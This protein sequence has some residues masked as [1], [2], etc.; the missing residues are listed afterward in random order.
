MVVKYG[1]LYIIEKFL[2]RD[3]QN[4]QLQ[5]FTDNLEYTV[6]TRPMYTRNIYERQT[7]T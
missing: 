1:M 5:K 3:L 7:T 2:P 6:Y 4:E